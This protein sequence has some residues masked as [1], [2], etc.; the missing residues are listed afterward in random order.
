MGHPQVD[1]WVG[2]TKRKA[3]KSGSERE[4][5]EKRGCGVSAQEPTLRRKREGWGTLKFMCGLVQRKGKKEKAGARESAE[6][7][8]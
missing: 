5:R 8:G 4:R 3:R 7:E 1:V 2:A 6:V